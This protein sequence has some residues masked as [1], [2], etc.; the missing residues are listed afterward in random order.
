VSYK[1]QKK[2]LDE[3]DEKLS[4]AYK[5]GVEAVKEELLHFVEEKVP[6]E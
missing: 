1:L 3:L 2:E 6:Y 4:K 5:R